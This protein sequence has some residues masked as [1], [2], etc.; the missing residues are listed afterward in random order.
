[1]I[2]IVH[3]VKHGGFS[4]GFTIYFQ[5]FLHLKLEAKQESMKKLAERVVGE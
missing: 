2:L 5:V 1:L 4:L 3:V